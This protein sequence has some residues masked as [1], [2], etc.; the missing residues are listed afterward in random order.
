M[1]NSINSFL[2][3]QTDSANICYMVP[4]WK[5][6]PPVTL[7]AFQLELDDGPATKACS[8]LCHLR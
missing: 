6:T 7:S 3:K 4:S 1:T 8:I 5:F 2:V